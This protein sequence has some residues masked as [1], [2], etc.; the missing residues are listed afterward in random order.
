MPRLEFIRG[1]AADDDSR[2]NSSAKQFYD[3]TWKAIRIKAGL[4][5]EE[6]FIAQKIMKKVAE[7][8]LSDFEGKEKE[9]Y[10]KIK[11]FIPQPPEGPFT[12]TNTGGAHKTDETEA[13]SRKAA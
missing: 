8:G 5:E 1:G 6:L 13:I 12:P 9:I 11:N 2:Q 7:E 10:D 3:E 4:S